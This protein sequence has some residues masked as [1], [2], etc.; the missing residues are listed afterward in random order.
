MKKWRIKGKHSYPS[1]RL[2]LMS[3]KR[4][5]SVV[6]VGVI[7][8][9]SIIGGVGLLQREGFLP[10][11]T[12]GSTVQISTKTLTSTSTSSSGATSSPGGAGTLVLQIHD[13]PNVPAGVSAVYVSYHDIWIGSSDANL[14]NLN[15]SG[16]INL[17][18]VVN[19]TQT[20]TNAKVE[21]GTFDELL[22]NMSSVL[23]TWNSL[24]YSASI[25]NDQLIIPIVGGLTI[26]NNGTSAAVIDISPTIIEQ[27]VYNST[28]S[29]NVSF[30]MVPSANA[31]V[32]PA[33]QLSQ[34]ETEVGDRQDVKNQAWLTS[35]IND[36]TR[37]TGFTILSSSVSNSSF[38]I[39]V[40]NTGNR[41]LTIQS[42]FIASNSSQA[43]EDD[44]SLNIGNSILFGVLPN[45]SLVPYGLLETSGY[46]L[47]AHAQAVFSY[48]GQIPP[49]NTY[50]GGEGGDNPTT[51]TTSTTVSREDAQSGPAPLDSGGDSNPYGFNIIAGQ[52]YFVGATSGDAT[53]TLM[54]VAT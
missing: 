21:A 35:Q 49:K 12:T 10:G 50:N 2:G 32:V 22:M 15:Q 51:Q 26:S 43:H 9:A 4:T 40:K 1:D 5:I 17:M 44:G 23:V 11:L 6:V 27:T 20:I 48:L 25:T 37:Q 45:G 8:A 30:V 33:N 38:V 14:V 31:Y 28:G 3:G 47:S 19:F 29:Q 42:V 46:N 34:A 53:S 36:S 41:S 18:A 52:S 7:L 13:P 16:T 24:N 54:I 39:A